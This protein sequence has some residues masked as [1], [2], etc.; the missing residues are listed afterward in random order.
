[1]TLPDG[2]RPDDDQLSCEH[3][4]GQ[5]LHQFKVE[6]FF[7]NEDAEEGIHVQI[8]ASQLLADAKMAGCPSLRRDGVRILLYCEECIQVTALTISQHKGITLVDIK[9]SGEQPPHYMREV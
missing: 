4:G 7:R 3:C 6:V 2:F 5:Y 8:D 9:P 1:V